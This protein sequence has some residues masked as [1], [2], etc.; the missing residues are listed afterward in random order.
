MRLLVGYLIVIVMF[1]CLQVARP[2]CSAEELT[3]R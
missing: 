2:D 1:L 3:G